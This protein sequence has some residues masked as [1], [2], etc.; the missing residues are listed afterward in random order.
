M[1]EYE[2]NK[3]HSYPKFSRLKPNSY[4][5]GL[6]QNLYGGAD[7][8]VCAFLQNTY[9]SFMMSAFGNENSKLFSEMA[10]EDI[11]HSKKLAELIIMLVGD[12][13][14]ASAQGKWLTGRSVDYIKSTRQMFLI[15]I[16]QKEKLIIDYKSAL[17]KIDEPVIKKALSSILQ[18]EETHLVKLKNIYRSLKT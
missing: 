12:P 17:L 14:Y 15:A 3:E 5:Q 2:L 8:E 6:L 1:K 11:F 7:G 18:D 10:E 9:H 4:Y 16:E 13:I